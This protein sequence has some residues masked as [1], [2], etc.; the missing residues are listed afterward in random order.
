MSLGKLAD[1]FSIQ[2][3][4]DAHLQLGCIDPEGLEVA[5]GNIVCLVGAN[6]A[7]KSTVSRA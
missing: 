7:C 3:A 2:A 1:E 6:N 4:E 5:I